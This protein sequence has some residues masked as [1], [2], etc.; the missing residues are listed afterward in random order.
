MERITMKLIVG[1]RASGKTT[2][3]IETSAREWKYIIVRDF[4]ETRSIVQKAKEM[5]LDIPY[6]I[7]IDEL[8]SYNLKQTSMKVD[9]IIID[10]AL[11]VLQ[12]IINVPITLATINVERED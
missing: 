8:L 2:K 3:A 9:G 11:D 12:K 7:T 5:K 10:N 1:N 6:P 4:S